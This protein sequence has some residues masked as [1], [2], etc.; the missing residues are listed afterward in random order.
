MFLT[1]SD[2]YDQ[3]RS[4]LAGEGRHAWNYVTLPLNYPWFCLTYRFS[5]NGGYET[6]LVSNAEQVA[7][8]LDQVGE[9]CSVDQILLVSPP[10]VNKSGNW[11]M[12]PLA[13]VWRYRRTKNSFSTDVYQLQDGRR[14]VGGPFDIEYAD[15][16][17]LTPMVT[18]K[19]DTSNKKTNKKSHF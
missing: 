11:Q 6:M 14:Y 16:E 10:S 3:T 17:E 4:R 19:P 7:S 2:A 5:A 8:I 18:F 1:S 9:D 15:I 13:K 12:D